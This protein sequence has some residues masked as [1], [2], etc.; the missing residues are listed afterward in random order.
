MS[1]ACLRITTA[2][3]QL[4]A[5]DPAPAAG[6]AAAVADFFAR[7]RAHFAPWDP[8]LPPD[9]NTAAA[10]QGQLVTGAAAFAAGQAWRW[11]LAL[12]DAPQRF[13]GSVSLSNLARGP[14]QSCA[15]GYSLDASAQGRGLMHEALEAVIAEAFAP[16]INLHRLQAGVRP[17]NTHSLAVLARLGFVDEGLARSYLY[18]DGAWRDHRIFSLS[19]PAFV[20]PSHW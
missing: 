4:Q 11:W 9:D 5:P 6:Q 14:S 12:A 16:A 18:I 8:P 17:E 1:V 19:N 7:N 3:L 13:I 20:A 2:R 15:L 10:V